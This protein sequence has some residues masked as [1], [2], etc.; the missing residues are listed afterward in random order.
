MPNFDFKPPVE[1]QANRL[2]QLLY[3]LAR[4]YLQ[5]GQFAEAYEKLKQ[6]IQLENEND[7]FLL[8]A[9]IAGLALNDF[10]EP[11]LTLYQRALEFNP[12]SKALRLN[13]VDFFLKHRI[14][15]PFAVEVCESIVEQNPANEPQ[16]RQ[17]L[18]HCYEVTGMVDKALAEE[19]RAIFT[20]RDVQA[21]RA[22][23]EKYWWE[24]KFSEAYA[25]LQSVPQVNG[26]AAYLNRELALT[27]AYEALGAPHAHLEPRAIE[28]M[29][30][31][32]AR[33]AP[34]DSFLDW[35]DYL[36][37][38]HTLH[39]K[40]VQQWWKTAKRD[41]LPFNLDEAPLK[42]FL[43]LNTGAQPQELELKGF[44]IA[45]EVLGVLNTPEAG[46]P[47]DE[48]AQAQWQGFMLAQILSPGNY[49]I[50]PRLVNLL[51][52]HLQQLPQTA[53]RVTGNCVISFVPEALPHLRAMIDF[54]QSLEDYNAA[55]PETERVFLS[56]V[57]RMQPIP[58]TGA[59]RDLL[60]ALVETSHLL[61][62]GEAA[63]PAEGGAGVLFLHAEEEAFVDLKS[64]G[65]QLMTMPS[66]TWWPGQQTSCA[67][68]IWRNPILQLKDG[69]QYEFGRYLIKQRL[70]RH[71]MFATY[72]ATDLLMDRQV[73]M[74]VMLPQA[75]ASFL[76]NE[77][78][79]NHLFDRI[80]SIGRVSHPYLAF[81]HEMGE[82]EGM[83]YFTRE[84][85]EG[86]NLSEL[87]IPEEQRDPEV[88]MLLQKIVRALQYAHDKGVVFMNLKPGNIWLSD[89]QELK[90]TDFRVPGFNEDASTASVLAP[91][92]WRYQAPEILLEGKGDTR[93]DVYSLGV[94]AYELL[95]GRHPYSTSR[96]IN[97]P[98]DIPKMRITSLGDVDKRHHRAWDKFVMR[99]LHLDAD[100]RFQSLEEMDGEIRAIQAEM[101]EKALKVTR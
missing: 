55:A 44:E 43:N 70:L 38:R 4:A 68:I 32:L 87:N 6:L 89:A 86:K 69:Q 24:A 10:S 28:N 34:A 35:R 39:A 67:E 12:A 76:Q 45:R 52:S 3:T 57:L 22:Y 20:S 83:V 15:N 82:H 29:L 14:V 84:Y 59:A 40:S 101:L 65:V 80:R 54:M 27:H 56:S 64:N 11:A 48:P 21:I 93:S 17:F 13:L 46:A 63:A 81:L 8:D 42:N 50:P 91:A 72:L 58:Q 95:V 30:C 97:S 18:R 9:A 23:M 66:V 75:S 53:V 7:E 19:R 99:A 100:R 96:S 94:I 31:A 78:K 90:I 71:T 51:S 77:R 85:V 60:K 61:R 62:M 16:L 37:L 25:A 74:K 49:P 33:L 2:N 47:Q 5:R 98:Q 1:Q 79:R 73:I 41:E 36:L 26:A 92:H 88:L